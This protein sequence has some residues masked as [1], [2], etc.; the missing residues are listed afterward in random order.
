MKEIYQRLW[1]FVILS[2]NSFQDFYYIESKLNKKIDI[3]KYN[4]QNHK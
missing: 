3:G 4:N 1:L 2:P